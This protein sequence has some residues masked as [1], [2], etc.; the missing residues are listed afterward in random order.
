MPPAPC[1][2]SPFPSPGHFLACSV[3]LPAPGK[4]PLWLAR[5]PRCVRGAAGSR[6]STCRPPLRRRGPCPV[7]GHRILHRRL[8]EGL[9]LC[10]VVP[11]P[12]SQRSPLC[13][14]G[15][16][17]RPQL[18]GVNAAAGSVL[19]S[20]PGG[21]PQGGVQPR[22]G[23]TRAGQGHRGCLSH[24]AQLALPRRDLC[25]QPPD[26]REEPCHVQG[27]TPAQ[28]SPQPLCRCWVPPHPPSRPSHRCPA[29]GP[30]RDGKSIAEPL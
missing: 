9:D 13:R 10:C 3:P 20:S 12:P 14:R 26:A 19:A 28:L 27:V 1:P 16:S 4:P 15:T 11:P 17:A 21:P 22:V 25:C 5:G 30:S 23:C 24:L 29:Q 18:D 2:A 6:S 7:Q 8:W